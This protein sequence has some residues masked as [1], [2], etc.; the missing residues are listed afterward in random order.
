MNVRIMI[1]DDHKIFREGLAAL[2][3]KHPDFEVVAEA[4]DGRSAVEIACRLKPQLVIMDIGMAGL[5]GIDATEQIVKQ[6]V[7]TKVIALSMH[8][9]R[10]YALKM[11]EA[12]ASGYVVKGA[13][14]NELLRAVEAVC[15]GKKYL[16]ADIA[17]VLIDTYVAR[18]APSG[19]LAN[20][21]LGPREREVLQLLSE[22][23]TSKEI[24][25]SMHISIKTA[26][27]HRRNIMQKLKIHT[28]AGLTKYAIR[29]G[30]TSLE[31]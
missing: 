12:G 29:L 5:N 4:S 9:D 3:E 16:S 6:S 22:G 27:T 13:G 1:V 30:L 11:L 26:N 15:A 17:A 20:P 25:Q 31:E 23:K 7:K 19:A 2:L 21:T 10:R 14:E 8:S 28:T 24:A 18:G